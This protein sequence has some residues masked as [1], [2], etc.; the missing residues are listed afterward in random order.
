MLLNLSTH[1]SAQLQE[2]SDTVAG[3]DRDDVC[4]ADEASGWNCWKDR[5][6]SPV[7]RPVDTDLNG[8]HLAELIWQ[9]QNLNVAQAL[10][11]V[12]FRDDR[13]GPF[14]LGDISPSGLRAR[15]EASRVP[16][17]VWAGWLDGGGGEDMLTRYKNFSNPQVVII[18][19]L[20]HGGGFNVDPLAFD[21]TPPVPTIE[22]QFTM[23]AIF[24]DR[25]LRN[26][27]PSELT[28]SI[29]YYTMGEGQWF[30]TTVWPPSGL[31]SLRLYFGANKMLHG[32]RHR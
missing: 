11:N 31:S 18:G 24:F 27:K 30:R 19:P 25:V 12:E 15:L 6:L 7:V 13:L 21:H 17:M 26:D 1:K 8:K 2:W 32:R 22:E 5:L 4:G 10:A 29:Q 16:M 9:R 20:S 23:E 28:S 3:L 14:S